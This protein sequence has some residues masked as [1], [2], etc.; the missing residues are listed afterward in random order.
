MDDRPVAAVRRRHVKLGEAP[1]M[2]IVGTLAARFARHQYAKV[3]A[4]DL[5]PELGGELA[6]AVGFEILGERPDEQRLLRP[7]SA[8]A[9]MAN[10]RDQRLVLER[11]AVGRG[12]RRVGCRR[13]PQRLTNPLGRKLAVILVIVTRRLGEERARLWL[14]ACAARR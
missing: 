12:D 3:A 11:L 4:A 9:E 8:L 7:A 13:R 2:D 10:C 6:L 5:A 1:G 14:A